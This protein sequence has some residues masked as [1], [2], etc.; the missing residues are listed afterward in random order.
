MSSN[1]QNEGQRFNNPANWFIKN[2]VIYNSQVYLGGYNLS[3]EVVDKCNKVVP[4]TPT[5]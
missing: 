1:S 3:K 2:D 4:F 5:L